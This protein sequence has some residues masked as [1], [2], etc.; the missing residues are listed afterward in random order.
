MNLNRLRHGNSK[1]A[2]SILIFDLPAVKT[3]PNCSACASTCYAVKTERRWRNVAHWRDYN[4]ELVK[5]DLEGDTKLLRMLCAQLSKEKPKYVRI[6][7][8]GDFFSQA[9][10]DWWEAIA[11]TFPKTTFYA[12]TKMYCA[13]DFKSFA[14]LPNVNILN[15]VVE[16]GKNFGSLEW[17]KEVSDRVG[18]PICPDTL[19]HEGVHCGETCTLCMRKTTERILFVQH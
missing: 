17:C 13:L 12:Y 3:C 14:N 16:Y 10:L 4:L 18:V 11:W 6:H 5:K 19:G 1:L 9:Y 8:S 15:S 7:S 2:K